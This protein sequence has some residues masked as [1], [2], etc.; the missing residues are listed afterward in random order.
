MFSKQSRLPRHALYP[1]LLLPLLGW[2]QADSLQTQRVQ[3]SLLSSLSGWAAASIA[4]GAWQSFSPSASTLRRYM[5][6]QNLAWGAVDGVIAG[7]GWIS[8]QKALREGRD[9]SAERRRLRRLLWINFGLDI[10]YVAAGAFLA[11]RSDPR[12]QGTGYGILIQGGFLLILDGWHA[13]RL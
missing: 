9:W 6:Y 8:R 12:W 5:G 13:L 10:G 2:G 1:T 11:S 7:I 3:R 4:V